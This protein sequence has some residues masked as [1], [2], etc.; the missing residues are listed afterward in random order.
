MTPDDMLAASGVPL[1]RPAY[2]ETVHGGRVPVMTDGVSVVDI[3]R[4]ATQL[5]AV[6]P[7]GQ[8][9]GRRGIVQWGRMAVF[10]T[11]GGGYA[12]RPVQGPLSDGGTR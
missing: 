9:R 8:S 10:L 5:V 3:P 1:W 4:K 7:A 12:S 2:R 6:Q 11:L